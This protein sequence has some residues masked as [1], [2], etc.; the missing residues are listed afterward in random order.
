MLGPLA[1]LL[2]LTLATPALAQSLP[3]TPRQSEGPYYPRVKPPETDADLTRLGAGPVAKG[4]VFVLK[5][6]VVDVAGRPIAGARVEIWQTDRQ[7]VYLHPDDPRTGRRDRDFQFYGETRS[8]GAGAFAFR[9]ITPARYPGRPPHIHA[10]IAPPG[11][12]TLT[13]QF[14]FAGDDLS[15][16]GIARRLG[17]ALADVTLT[18][19]PGAGGEREA[20]VRVVLPAAR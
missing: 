17:A 1:T 2:A 19:A 7:G 15:G 5:G 13:T 18:P 12:P 10:K 4:D 11:G 16:D 3:L 9:T 14:Y 6:R 8:D 20:T